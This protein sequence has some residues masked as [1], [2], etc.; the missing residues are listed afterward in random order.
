[1]HSITKKEKEYWQ[2]ELNRG[3]GFV[4][5]KDGMLNNCALSLSLFE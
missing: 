5:S 4:F 3:S 1:M 2:M